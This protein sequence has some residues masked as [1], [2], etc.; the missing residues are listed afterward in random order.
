MHPELENDIYLIHNSADEDWVSE[1]AE[2]LEKEQY[3]NRTLKVFFSPWDV[4]EGRN[5]ILLLNKA[6]ERARFAAIILSPESIN[7]EWVQR[8][9]T[10]A[11][12]KDVSGNAG[13]LIPVLKRNCDIPILL[14]VLDWVDFTN[15]MKYEQAYKALVQ[16]I[17]GEKKPRRLVSSSGQSSEI[18]TSN[19]L[20]SVLLEPILP[21]MV[22]EQLET[23]IFPVIHSARIPEY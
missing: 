13:R 3:E 7:S 6:L 23:N 18:I 14:R 19:I 4:G 20:S 12:L 15:P 16:R 2:R 5:F 11:I 17:K 21:D 10:A 8:E 1:L 22:D 9:W